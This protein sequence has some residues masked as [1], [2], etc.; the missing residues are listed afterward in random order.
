MAELNEKLSF[1]ICKT[2]QGTGQVET[3]TCPECKG[4]GVALFL[5]DKVLYWGKNLD[6]ANIAFDR[7]VRK[8]KIIFNLIL[9]AVGL[10]GVVLMAYFAYQD[11]FSSFLTMEYWLEPSLEKLYF[12]ITLLVDLYLYYRLEQESSGKNHVL[13]KTFYKQKNSPDVGLAWSEILK[14]KK[15]DLVD[16]SKAFSQDSVKAV[17]AAWELTKHF[18]HH[19]VLRVHLFAVLAQFEKSGVILARLGVNF[20]VF[21]QKLSNYLSKKIISRGGRPHLTVEFYKTLLLAYFI[22]YE[23][24]DRKVEMPEL[25]KALAMPEE[26]GLSAKQADDI[27]EVMLD[28]GYDY[29]KIINVVAWVRI[30]QQLRDNLSRFRGKARYKPKS[31]MDRA[32][33]AMATPLLDKFSEDLTLKAKYG[34]L[35]PCIGREDEI[36]HIFR[37]MEGSREGVLLV[38]NQGVG[39]TTVI[40]GLAQRM[41]TEEVPESL[42]DKRLVSLDISRLLAGA[43]ASSAEQRLLMITDEV[44]RAGNIIL[45]VENTHNLF[46]ISAG[47]EA[48]LDLSEVFAQIMS[49]HLFYV[50]ATTTPDAYT[51]SIEG[52][53]LDAEFQ[54]I[55]IQEL[56]MNDAIQVLEV[57]SGPI[58]YQ[59]QVYFSYAAIERAA[60]LS[61][62][63]IQDKYLPDKAIDIM[64]QVAIKV[65]KT[66]GE[67]QVI[68]GEDVAEIIST[69]T[70]VPVTKVTQAES[71]KLLNLE[72]KI[73]ER[74]VDQEE[75]VK[76]V[77]ASLR[78]ARAE[79][80]EGKR[81]I[82]SLL[83]L[84]PT[85]VGKTE[86]TKAVAEIYFG[87]EKAMTRF[88]MSEFQST[89]SIGRLIGSGSNPGQLTEAVRKNPFSLLLF[90][91]VEKADKDVLNLFLQVMDD[92]RLTDAKGHTIDF[93]S[94]IIIMTSNAG[95]QYIQD[96]INKGTTIDKIKSHLINEELK[97]YYKP[98]FLNR[99]DGVVVFKPLT[100]TDV[101][102]IARLMVAKVGKKLD[103]KGIEFS[104]TDEAI[105][106]LA[107][108]GFDP[109]FGARP[110]RRVIQEKIDDVLADALLKG[111]IKR[112]DKVVLHPEGQLKVEKAE[113]I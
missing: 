75:A 12:W 109:K 69:I 31:G 68:S 60:A 17:Q 44:A 35:F 85:G 5:Q 21:K 20:E 113:E 105:A 70:K 49:R 37:I 107:E 13:V 42:Q 30:Q 33:T 73:H 53:G 6:P 80:R 48:S 22:A 1:S 94:T 74:M 45:A 72:E 26:I 27:N 16:V 112:R 84:G 28:M 76:L 10:S 50:I 4:A 78:R 66:R 77:A 32:M 3:K 65:K 89:D 55:Q 108:L 14:L 104:V 62:R 47:K 64:E 52:R 18:E 91:E 51:K 90:D 2:C 54:E 24:N 40:H 43:D 15:K 63:Y 92:G 61:A 19:E 101:I 110:L 95:A 8:I 96:E 86:L 7:L 88:D 59:N 98:E 111:E 81:P 9:A 87:N 56:E 58:E 106:E 38:G 99:F 11:N 93:T 23:D 82:A 29:Q 46:G 102:Q 41:V 79:L 100:M 97:Q 34:Q 25:V 36:E 39:R 67:K 103:D 57:K 71:E 83:F